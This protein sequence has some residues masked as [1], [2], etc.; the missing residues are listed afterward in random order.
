LAFKDDVVF[1][2]QEVAASF[3]SRVKVVEFV[4]NG[5]DET[6]RA[7]IESITTNTK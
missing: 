2:V 1:I 6:A 7:E 3:G 4:F 5:W